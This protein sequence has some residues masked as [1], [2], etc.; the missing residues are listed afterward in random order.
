MDMHVDQRRHEEAT[1]PLDDDGVCRNGRSLVGR[2]RFDA[3]V[4]NDYGLMIEPLLG[5]HRHDAHVT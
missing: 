5:S 3:A 1:T 2:N 4:A